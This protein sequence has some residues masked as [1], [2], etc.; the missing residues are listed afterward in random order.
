[1]FLPPLENTLL[2]FTGTWLLQVLVKFCHWTLAE[3]ID[4]M[5]IIV[6][7]R[8]ISLHNN[9]PATF[10][11]RTAASVSHLIRILIEEVDQNVM[12]LLKII[13]YLLV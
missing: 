1:M 8:I 4:N 7:Q 11:P 3:W 2:T 13:F 9:V 12:H 5:M 6:Y 10:R